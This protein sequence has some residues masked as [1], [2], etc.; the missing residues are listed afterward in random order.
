MGRT[1]LDASAQQSCPSPLYLKMSVR[2]LRLSASITANSCKDPSARYA[3]PR[4]LIRQNVKSIL[5]STVSKS[6]TH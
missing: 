1:I 4:R 6:H 3:D 2:L 5:R